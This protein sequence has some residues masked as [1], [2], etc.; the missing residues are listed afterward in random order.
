MS[1][2]DQKNSDAAWSRFLTA[3]A[4][5]IE[6]LDSE[7]MSYLDIAERVGIAN[8]AVQ[9]ILTVRREKYKKLAACVS[10]EPL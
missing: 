8:G 4:D 1:N 2:T 3:Q 5:L 7:G 9:P 10:V 6:A